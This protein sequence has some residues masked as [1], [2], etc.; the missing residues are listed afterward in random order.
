[1]AKIKY[2]VLLLI[3]VLVFS[4]CSSS[5]HLQRGNYDT[6]IEKAVQNLRRNPNNVDEI[7]VLDQAYNIANEQN[8]ER[9][10]FLKRE[11]NPRNTE[12]ILR[13]YTRM[14]NRQTLVRTVLPL[15]LPD[16]T[17]EY[18]YVDYDEAIIEAKHG[19]AGYYYENALRLMDLNEKD[20]YRQAYHEL[21]RVEEYMG[22]YRDTDILIREAYEKGLSRALVVVEN[23]TH[24]N[25]SPAFK[26]ELLTV[27]TRTLNT[28][29]VEYHFRDLDENLEFDYFLVV[30]LRMINVSPNETKEKDQV[31][32]KE[33]ED[34]FEYLLDERGNVMKDS[35]GNDIR[36]PRYKELV[37][38]VIETVQI[39]EAFI[40]GDIEIYSEVPRMLLKREPIGAKSLFEHRSARAVGDIEALDEEMKKMVEVEPL[41]FPDDAEMV[42]RTAETLRG[43]ISRAIRSNRRYIR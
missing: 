19:A 34:G 35:L 8:L 16:R 31:V 5:R 42:F 22:N 10:R 12:E 3:L 7:L 40:E 25:L 39:K 27:D 6:A 14:K 9:I 20:S 38:A 21:R 41:P 28:Q 24:L 1:M 43:A 32:K 13:L 33:V 37:C 30:N 11:N 17:I 36:I 15:Q 23:H 18:P 26:N 4:G 2:S 29:W